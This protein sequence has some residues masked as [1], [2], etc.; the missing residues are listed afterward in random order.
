MGVRGKG[1]GRWTFEGG[2]KVEGRVEG[3]CETR[4]TLYVF[5]SDSLRIHK[6]LSTYS[7]LVTLRRLGV[8]TASRSSPRGG[9]TSSALGLR[10]GFLARHIAITVANSHDRP[11]GSATDDG[12]RDVPVTSPFFAS[13]APPDTPPSSSSLSSPRLSSGGSLFPVAA[14]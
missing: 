8:R 10:V 5:M 13:P 2:E 12:E 11:S 14:S 1:R 3:N 7:Y 4:A 9:D 6:R